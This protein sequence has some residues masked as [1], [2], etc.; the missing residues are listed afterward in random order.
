MTSAQMYEL[1]RDAIA[2]AEGADAESGNVPDVLWVGGVL[3]DRRAVVWFDGRLYMVRHNTSSQ[4][5][6]I[7]VYEKQ[8]DA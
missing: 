8:A 3:E 7:D 4:K 5:T 1:A 6:E 2:Q